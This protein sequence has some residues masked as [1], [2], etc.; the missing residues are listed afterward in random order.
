MCRL[1]AYKG[2]PMLIGDLITNP[3]NSLVHQSRHAAYHPGVEDKTHTRNIL[4][5]GDGFGLSWYT[6]SKSTDGSAACF[7]FVTPA[8]SNSN[9]R[10]IGSHVATS[11]LFAHVRAASSGNEISSPDIAVS[12]EN[13]HPFVYGKFTFMHNGGIANFKKVKLQ[14]LNQLS[15]D[16]FQIIKGSTDSEHIFALFL[17][18]LYKTK[19]S[20]FTVEDMANA[21]D[22]TISTIIQ[23]CMA[24]D[25][26]DPC[27]INICVTDG[28]HM[29]ATRFRNGPQNP[30]SLYYNYGSKFVCE[31][32]NFVATGNGEAC[33]VVISSAPLSRVSIQS[34]RD[35]DCEYVSTHTDDNGSWVLMPKDHMLICRADP[36]NPHLVKSIE[37]RPI[38]ITLPYLINPKVS[39]EIS[40]PPSNKAALAKLASSVSYAPQRKPKIIRFR[41]KL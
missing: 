25:I 15:P 22:T 4:V 6:G 13:C 37:L 7:K 3:N 17:T 16:F 30:P 10:S 29:L 21:I 8:W 39:E 24:A 26:E 31:D 27:S 2:N 11:L 38:V 33:D 40:A 34:C 9:L 12:Q 23:L 14:L 35:G 36:L 1:T 5:N 19:S 20:N 28:V 18:F 32:G 41:S